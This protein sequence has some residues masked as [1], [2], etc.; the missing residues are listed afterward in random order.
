MSFQTRKGFVILGTQFKICF[1]FCVSLDTGMHLLHRFTLWFERKQRT[2]VARLIQKSVRILRPG[3]NLQ[4][5]TTLTQ[6]RCYVPNCWIKSLL[7]LISYKN[8]SR[9]FITFRLNHWWQMEYPSDAFHSFLDLDSVTY[10][11]VNRTVTSLPVLSSKISLIVFRRWTKLLWVWNNMGVSDKWQ[12]FHFG[13][14]YPFKTG[15]L[16]PRST[17][18]PNAPL[19]PLLFSFP[20]SVLFLLYCTYDVVKHLLSQA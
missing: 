6:M 11:A 3:D 10:L 18:T 13:V 19:P 5:G 1:V 14:E 17:W 16:R 12:K 4:N 2:F 8:Y 20:L 9:R 7:F 15:I